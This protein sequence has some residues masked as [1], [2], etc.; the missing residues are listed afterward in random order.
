MEIMKN[1]IKT[2]DLCDRC[3]YGRCKVKTSKHF[4]CGA[5]CPLYSAFGCKCER[6]RRN[7]PCPYFREVSENEE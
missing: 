4:Q 1:N 2:D 7:T 6:I 3:E 5:L